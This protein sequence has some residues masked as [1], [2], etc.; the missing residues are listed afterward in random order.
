MADEISVLYAEDDRDW[1]YMVKTGLE[2]NGFLVELAEDGNIA[3]QK[4]EEKK[5]DIVILDIDM[6]GKNGWELIHELKKIDPWLPIV[7]YTAH[8]TSLNFI[9]ACGVG[10]EDFIAKGLE[11]GAFSNR[12]K[13]MYARC[14]QAKENS[15]VIRISQV[16]NFSPDNG[17]LKVGTNSEIMRRN[18]TNLLNILCCN[19]NKE[20][21]KEDLCFAIW[22]DTNVSN[23]EATLRNVV[24]ELRKYLLDDSSVTIKNIRW[25]GYGLIVKE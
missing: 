6:P 21:S 19:L 17:V 4:L 12:L 22:G 3:W 5:Y 7:L 13:T 20:V 25:G 10:A 2:L 18:E 16:T 24:V 23:R 1:S 11:L 14:C 8:F 15:N 9:D